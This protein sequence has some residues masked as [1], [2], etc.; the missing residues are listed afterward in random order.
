MDNPTRIRRRLHMHTPLVAA[1]PGTEPVEQTGVGR[2]SLSTKKTW[3]EPG[4]VSTCSLVQGAPIRSHAPRAN[5][6]LSGHRVNDP[7]R[8][9][10][11][12][13][14]GQ[15]ACGECRRR[16][17]RSG[18][19]RSHRAASS[20][21]DGG[22]CTTVSLISDGWG[23]G[24]ARTGDLHLD[25]TAVPRLRRVQRQTRGTSRA[26]PPRPLRSISTARDWVSRLW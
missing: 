13:L 2:V 16:R 19:Q 25:R 5:I 24:G 15:S 7:R 11:L 23:M 21:T 22:G 26:P 4:S 14:H 20:A 9:R 8:S 18:V 6:A 10:W 17:S 12:V 3:L 1:P